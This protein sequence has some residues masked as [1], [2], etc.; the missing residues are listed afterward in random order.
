MRLVPTDPCGSPDEWHGTYLEEQT[1][2][3]IPTGTTLFEVM[4]LDQPWGVEK[5]IG[6]IITTSPVVTS[7]WG[8]TQLFFRHTRFE[9]DIAERPLWKNYV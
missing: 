5:H 9:E 2:G 4:A 8:D 7:L 6:D 3:C 1:S